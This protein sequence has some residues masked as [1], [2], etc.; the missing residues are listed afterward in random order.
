MVKMLQFC[1][2]QLASQCQSLPVGLLTEK[3][4]AD[5]LFNRIRP[6]Q[7]SVSWLTSVLVSLLPEF[8][9]TFLLID[10][11]NPYVHSNFVNTVKDIMEQDFGN[12]SIA[13]YCQPA[14]SLEPLLEIADVSIRLTQIEPDLG[15]Y[16][17]HKIDRLV[18]PRLVAANLDYDDGFLST[19]EQVISGA[20][21]GL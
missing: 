7:T 2:I 13:V 3:L 19:I 12:V 20:A 21:D 10:V 8:R 9:R 17:R 4:T 6:A 18:K 1:I 11:D 16:T 5:E 15:Q 14:S